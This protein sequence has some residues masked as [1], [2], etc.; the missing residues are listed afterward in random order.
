MNAY[1]EL[2]EF[3]SSAKQGKL[4]IL[5]VGNDLR[6]DDG[7]GPYIAKKLHELTEISTLIYDTGNQPENYLSVLAREQITHCLI[8]DAVEF[9]QNP[10]T[11]G[12][13]EPNDL[14]EYQVT[15]STHFL[16][17]KTL[18]NVFGENTGAT[19]KVLGIQPKNLEFGSTMCEEVE[20]AALKLFALLHKLLK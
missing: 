16:S 20:I 17:M 15:F 8:V 11:I 5:C 19:F 1:D 9:H 10:G 4:A 2:T 3:I 13:F 14:K 7:L 6:G 12:F 18:I